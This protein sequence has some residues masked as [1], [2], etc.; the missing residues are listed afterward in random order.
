MQYLIGILSA[1]EQQQDARAHA[2]EFADAVVAQGD[3]DYHDGE[4]SR[5]Y[6]LTSALGRKT[7][8]EAQAANRRDF[9]RAIRAARLIRRQTNAVSKDQLPHHTDHLHPGLPGRQDSE[10]LQ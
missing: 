2:L 7:I 4:H 1:G 3:V 8:E 5:T 10:L 6:R 9:D